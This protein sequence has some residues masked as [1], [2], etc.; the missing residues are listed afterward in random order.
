MINITWDNNWKIQ[1]RLKLFK[2]LSLDG[3]VT[4]NWKVDEDALDSIVTF[5]LLLEETKNLWLDFKM[6]GTKLWI[7]RVKDKQYIY[8]DLKWKDWVNGKDGS[9]WKDWVDWQDWKDWINGK[10]GIDWKD[11]KDWIDWQDWKDGVWLQY[12]WWGQKLWIKREDEEEY[13]Y[14]DLWWVKWSWDWHFRWSNYNKLEASI[15]LKASHSDA[16]A[17]SIA[18]W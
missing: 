18:L 2:N 6:N 12:K 3:N 16:I 11:G 5:L 14:I 15:N 13:D 10:N 1:E 9:D 4:I 8:T 7:K 17:Y